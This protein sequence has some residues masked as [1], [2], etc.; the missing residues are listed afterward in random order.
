MIMVLTCSRRYVGLKN[1]EL[2]NKRIRECNNKKI[3]DFANYSAVRKIVIAM[4]DNIE[5]GLVSDETITKAVEIKHLQLPDYWLTCALLS[6]MAWKN[7][8]KES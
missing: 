4:L 2:A 6:L 5:L 8:D 3:Y 1:I 7:D